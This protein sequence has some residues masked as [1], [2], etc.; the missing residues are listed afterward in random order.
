MAKSKPQ[1]N[2]FS[3]SGI[4]F[5]LLIGAGFLGA[6]WYYWPSFEFWFLKHY[7]QQFHSAL[8]PNVVVGIYLLATLVA[9]L[10]IS[11]LFG[12]HSI[13]MG[14]FLPLA[15]FIGNQEWIFYHKTLKY[16]DLNGVLTLLY[17]VFSKRSW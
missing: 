13:F 15:I 17:T 12:K 1:R 9:V 6:A 2:S 14:T 8:N 3:L 5:G 10:I 11:R 16:I 4:L 7:L